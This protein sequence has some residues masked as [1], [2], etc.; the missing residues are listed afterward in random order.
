MAGSDNKNVTGSKLLAIPDW[1][2]VQRTLWVGGKGVQTVSHRWIEH[3]S[4]PPKRPSTFTDRSK[5]KS[6]NKDG[7]D[8]D[9]WG[10][11]SQVLPFEQGSG[12]IVSLQVNFASHKSAVAKLIEAFDGFSRPIVELI[13]EA[14][15]DAMEA[16]AKRPVFK[17]IGRNSK[18]KDFDFLRDL[19]LKNDPEY[20]EPK[21]QDFSDLL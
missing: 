3:G 12:G 5:W 2:I 13:V 20:P 7:K 10:S 6:Y 4:A 18:G 17:I 11:I 15:P 8:F 19:L 9:P 21:P 1:A 14:D 16:G